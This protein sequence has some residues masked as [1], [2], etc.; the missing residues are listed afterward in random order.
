[1]TFPPLVMGRRALR[2]P[3]SCR[4]FDPE[5]YPHYDHAPRPAGSCVNTCRGTSIGDE[6]MPQLAL[7]SDI[8]CPR[9]NYEV[10]LY[11]AA[12]SAPPPPVTD[13]S[14]EPIH[15]IGA[16]RWMIIGPARCYSQLS[17]DQ[18]PV[19]NVILHFPQHR[20]PLRPARPASPPATGAF[21]HD[22]SRARKSNTSRFSQAKALRSRR[23]SI[24]E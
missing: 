14:R 11:A 24:A 3:S 17:T 12:R 16:Q 9:W 21:V 15:R 2:V 13:A 18:F 20:F 19:G 6:Q 10:R 22:V 23:R 5:L 7:H 8:E 1:M 4:C